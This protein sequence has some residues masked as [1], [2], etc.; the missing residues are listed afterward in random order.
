MS[1]L[2]ITL[3]SAVAL[4]STLSVSFSQTIEETMQG[5]VVQI[6]NFKAGKKGKITGLGSGTGFVIND[7]GYIGTNHHVIAGAARNKDG[8]LIYVNL[9]GETVNVRDAL[10]QPNA[11]VIWRS[12]GLDL[13][14]LKLKDPVP[15]AIRS[16]VFTPTPPEKGGEVIAIGY[17]GAAN[18]DM[19]KSADLSANATYTKGVLG[20]QSRE[21]WRQ[22][23]MSLDIIQHSAAVSWGNSGGPLT[24]TCGRLVGVNT[25]VS[26]KGKGFINTKKGS[27]QVKTQAP[28]VYYASAISNLITVLDKKQISYKISTDQCLSSDQKLQQTFERLLIGVAAVAVIGIGGIIG[29]IIFSRR[30]KTAPA[31]GGVVPSPSPAPVSPS[32]QPD[33]GSASLQLHGRHLKSG[34]TFLITMAE[35][36]LKNGMQIIGREPANSL[37]VIPNS[38][39]SR[40]HAGIQ[41]KSGRF[42]IEDR[43]STNGTKL[44][45]RLL[46]PHEPALLNN[47]DLVHLGSEIEI[48][49]RLIT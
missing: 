43:N 47:N 34:E 19:I 36:D 31:N 29:F 28:G 10:L 30:N 6:Y 26:L 11:T 16:L 45:G 12:E 33:P 15:T 42:F 49:A 44:N 23:G 9:D 3:V 4:L 41:L 2:K 37:F 5:G 24:D 25:Q 18:R 17:P 1:F 13:A 48:T 21:P 22:A 20:R 8:E 7:Q 27:I 40:E 38:S 39:V 14:I 32:Q 35:S 46:K